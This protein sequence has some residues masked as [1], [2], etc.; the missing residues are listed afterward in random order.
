[1]LFGIGRLYK[2]M[3][4]SLLLVREFGEQ[5][6]RPCV[7]KKMKKRLDFTKYHCEKLKTLCP[8]EQNQPFGKVINITL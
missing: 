2:S 4:M 5:N 6:R 8:D 3:K 7:R 1:M